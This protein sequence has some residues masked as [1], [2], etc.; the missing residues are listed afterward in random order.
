[1]H[2]DDRLSIRAG[3]RG[4]WEEYECDSTNQTPPTCTLALSPAPQRDRHTDP[5]SLVCGEHVVK[6]LRSSL[7]FVTVL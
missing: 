1:M 4:S 3:W 5:Q 6:Q 2:E 7:K